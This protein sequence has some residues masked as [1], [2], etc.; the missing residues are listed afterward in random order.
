ML[1]SPSAK[2]LVALQWKISLPAGLRLEAD[3]I[4][5]GSAAEKAHKTITCAK[6]RETEPTKAGPTFSCV[7]AGGQQSISDGP[8]A[9]VRVTF[10]MGLHSA[11]VLVRE[12]KGVTADLKGLTIP[13]AE[14]TVSVK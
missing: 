10:P 12:A 4:A 11:K 7:L 8:L 5:V 3:D 6:P 2:Q 9:T 13:D 14:G 1:A